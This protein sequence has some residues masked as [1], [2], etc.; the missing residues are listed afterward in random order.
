MF[1]QKDPDPLLVPL[2]GKNAIGAEK[3]VCVGVVG[4]FLEGIGI[5]FGLSMES[6]RECVM[7]VLSGG[8]TVAGGGSLGGRVGHYLQQYWVTKLAVS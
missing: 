7:A 6:E 2:K 8:L 4:G 3:V 5:Y 1:T